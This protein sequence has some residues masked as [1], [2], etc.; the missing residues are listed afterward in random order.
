MTARYIHKHIYKRKCPAIIDELIIPKRVASIIYMKNPQNGIYPAS[1]DRLVNIYNK[2]PQ[3]VKNKN[4][5]QFKRYLL[6]HDVEP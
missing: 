1:L 6:K 2:L 5:S 4:P 3:D